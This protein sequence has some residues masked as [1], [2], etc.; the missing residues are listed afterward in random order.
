[1]SSTT[2]VAGEL[3]GEIARHDGWVWDL[4]NRSGRVSAAVEPVTATT[5]GATGHRDGRVVLDGTRFATSSHSVLA[6][7]P[8]LTNAPRGGPS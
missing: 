6:A 5:A 2:H 4:A 7:S 1:M 3:L 8:H